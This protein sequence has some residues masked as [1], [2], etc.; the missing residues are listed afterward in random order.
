M[1]V[2][3]LGELECKAVSACACTAPA[4]RISQE[5]VIG[6]ENN[7]SDSCGG[8]RRT[9]VNKETHMQHVES[10]TDTWGKMRRAAWSFVCFV[11][12]C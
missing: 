11:S 4:K 6:E 10:G 1:L 9:H 3:L 2:A 7:A 12:F 5:P 8:D